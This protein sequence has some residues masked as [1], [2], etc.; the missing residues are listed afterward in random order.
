M[1]KKKKNHVESL[2]K[3][4]EFESLVTLVQ[5]FNCFAS[6]PHSVKLKLGYFLELQ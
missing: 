4:R 2:I 5:T 6:S 3:R 1:K